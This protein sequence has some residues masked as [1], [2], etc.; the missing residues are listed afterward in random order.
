MSA[1]TFWTSAGPIIGAVATAVGV[2]VG[3]VVALTKL[4]PER[5]AI[6]V[7]TAEKSVNI[8]VGLMERLEEELGK[9]NARIEALEV[10]VRDLSP[11]RERV[12]AVEMARDA[13]RREND[14]LRGKLAEVT[15]ENERLRDRVDALEAE[16][17][18]LQKEEG[19]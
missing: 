15:E 2:A 10:K 11:L 8:S 13:Y 7:T 19:T 9:A 6:L 14:A 1:A 3:L 16:V 18:Q 5:G 12:Q 17:S 4:G